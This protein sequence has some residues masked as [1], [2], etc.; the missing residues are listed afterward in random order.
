M[1][2][3]I[4]RRGDVKAAQEAEYVQ[5]VKDVKEAYASGKK[6]SEIAQTSDFTPEKLETLCQGLKFNY[7]EANREEILKALTKSKDMASVAELYE[8]KPKQ[9]KDALHTWARTDEKADKV[10]KS[11][12]V[13]QT[14]TKPTAKQDEAVEKEEASA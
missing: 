2:K 11:F 13:A 6:L 7:L 5:K 9:L 12:I 8:V 3:G 1:I 14:E 4:G 10:L